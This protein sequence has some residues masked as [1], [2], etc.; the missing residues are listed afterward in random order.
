MKESLASAEDV[1]VRAAHRGK[2]LG[3]DALT[4]TLT[5]LDDACPDPY[6]NAHPWV[7]ATLLAGVAPQHLPREEVARAGSHTLRGA[8]GNPHWTVC[9]TPTWP[10]SCCAPAGRRL[11][12]PA[13]SGVAADATTYHWLLRE[14]LGAG[15]SA[16][17]APQKATRRRGGPPPAWVVA[18]AAA[19]A[20]KTAA[21]R[22]C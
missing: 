6:V 1:R 15:Y 13:P 22:I 3:F 19:A 20:A 21:F 17:T 4:A 10:R 11:P 18:Q 16:G 14:R 2:D 9:G 5:F 12:W 8:C 7:L